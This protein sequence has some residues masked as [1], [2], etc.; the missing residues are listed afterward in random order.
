GLPVSADAIT[1]SID[2]SCRITPGRRIPPRGSAHESRVEA[3]MKRNIQ[4]DDKDRHLNGLLREDARLPTAALA[5]SLGVAR[6]TVVERLKRLEK[7]GVISGYTVR[8]SDEAQ[9]ARMKVHAL[10]SVD[11]KKADTV[12][13]ALRRIIQ[14][15]AV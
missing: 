9:R 14:V 2:E 4:L 1:T 5:R 13:Q 11:A 10:L 8:L 15:R 7:A 12:V 6:T 3:T